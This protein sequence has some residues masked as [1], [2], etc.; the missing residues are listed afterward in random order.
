LKKNNSTIINQKNLFSKKK[1]EED[2][3]NKK[4]I[5]NVNNLDDISKLDFD[6]LK[7]TLSKQ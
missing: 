5:K 4:E 2:L 7:F 6:P 1:N 3:N